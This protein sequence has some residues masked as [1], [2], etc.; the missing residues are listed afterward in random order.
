[1]GFIHTQAVRTSCIAAINSGLTAAG[2]IA[3]DGI[4]I[5]GG[6]ISRGMTAVAGQAEAVRGLTEWVIPKQKPRPDT[7]ALLQDA[8]T[9][10]SLDESNSENIASKAAKG[11]V[12]PQPSAP[13]VYESL[14][15]LKPIQK[16]ISEAG[17]AIGD[18]A[19]TLASSDIPEIV[20]ATV[21]VGAGGAAGAGILT[22]TAASGTAG[23]AWL[24]SA[25]AGA[26]H[27]V[28][29]TMIAG[30]WVTAAPAVILAA[31]GVWAVGR[32]NKKRLIEAKEAFLQEALRKRDVLLRE[33]HAT[34]ASNHERVDCLSRLVAQL[35]AAVENLQADLRPA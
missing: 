34:N 13:A 28:G 20:G 7:E 21:G 6:G 2:E 10:F 33:L 11:E 14:S 5:A 22:A 12:G 30:I 9:N 3:S 18:R 29:G 1:M 35:Q 17:A 31:A 25:L 23:A 8:S 15:A 24:T 32:H 16:L 19:R 27:L 26:G 4:K